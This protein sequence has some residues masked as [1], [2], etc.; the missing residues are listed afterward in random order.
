ML[1]KYPVLEYFTRYA[2]ILGLVLA[3][4]GIYHFMLFVNEITFLDA[5]KTFLL[6]FFAPMLFVLAVMLMDESLTKMFVFFERPEFDTEVLDVYI[7]IL[8]GYGVL[9]NVLTFLVLLF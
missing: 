5:I 4:F 1:M 6:F 7:I 2:T 9:F 3:F 8:L